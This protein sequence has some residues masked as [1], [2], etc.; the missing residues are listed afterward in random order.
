M[1]RIDG[2][3]EIPYGRAHLRVASS[4]SLNGIFRAVTVTAWVFRPS[5]ASPPPGGATVLSRQ[6]GYA[7]GFDGENPRWAITVD[8]RPMPAV[9]TGLETAARG[10]WIHM[11]GTFDGIQARLYIDG[12]EVAAV[13]FT[14]TVG[15]SMVPLTLGARLATTVADE[16]LGGRLDD[17]RLYAR[18]LAPSEIA[19]LSAP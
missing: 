14:G 4:V 12:R 9:L 15:S 7:L 19:A 2:A 18:A 11:A 8:A 13:A 5:N 3:I 17:V 10:R 1:G 16:P 6:G